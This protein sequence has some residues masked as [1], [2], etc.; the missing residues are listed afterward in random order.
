MIESSSVVEGGSGDHGGEPGV[1]PR[2][3]RVILGARLRRL[4]E[5]AGIS[6]DIAGNAIRA[7]HSKISRMEAGRVG[8]RTRDIEDLL[9]VYG[10]GDPQRRAEYLDLARR[11]NAA[12]Q[13]HADVGSP[14]QRWDTYFTL[15][16]AAALIRSYAPGVMPPLLQTAAYAQAIL[17]V[18]QQGSTL[19]LQRRVEVLIRRQRLLT[20]PDAPRLWV[21]VEEA[22]LRRPLGGT[23][24]WRAQLEYLARTALRPNVTVQI[25]PDHR[26]GPAISAVPFTMLRFGAADLGDLVHLHHATGTQFLDRRSDLDAYREIWDRLSVVAMAPE[27]TI[28]RIAAI[29][30]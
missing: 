13:W 6:G 5:A 16:D 7:S 27:Q 18:A 26:G 25:L 15:E 4:R 24:V 20:R 3:L 30:G 1:D 14:T 21:V 10:I 12:S 9:T 8:C 28:D 2:L 29:L 19:E 22:A 11:A 17:A 23:A